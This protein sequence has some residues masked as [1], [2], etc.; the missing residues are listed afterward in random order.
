[1]EAEA[2]L[3]RSL[4]LPIREQLSSLAS[5][6][7]LPQVHRARIEKIFALLTRESLNQAPKPPFPGLSYI[8]ANGLPFQWV[9]RFGG[10][11]S[12]FGFLCEVGKPGDRPQQRLKL[13]LERL[14]LACDVI[15][16]PRSFWLRNIVDRVIPPQEDEPWPPHLK[17]ALWVGVAAG[18]AGIQLKPY[19]NLN[20]GTA[21]E[22]WLRAGWVLKD[23]GRTRSL[24]RL[25]ELSQCASAGGWPVGLAADILPD[26]NAGRIKIYFRSE[27]VSP[28]WLEHWYKAAGFVRGATAVRR[29]LDLFP[30]LGR[31]PYPS[32]AFILCVESH[33]EDEI[34]LKTDLAVSKWIASDAEVVNGSRSLVS[35]LGGNPKLIEEALGA[36]GA[37]PPNS[38]MLSVMRFVSLGIELDGSHHVNL[39]VEPPL[40]YFNGRGKR[41]ASVTNQTTDEV[42]RA[43]LHYLISQREGSRWTDFCLPVG[44]SDAWVTAYVLARLGDL[45]G[46][47]I[48][49]SQQEKIEE[50]LD[51]LLAQRTQAGGWGYNSEVPDDADSTA[52]AILA[53]RCH[54]REVPHQ[55][56]DVLLRCEEPDGTFATYPA[57]TEPGGGW[58]LAVPDVTAV[59]LK[60]LGR[61]ERSGVDAVLSRWLHPEGLPP[62][63]WWVSPFYTCA[64]LLDGCKEVA[65]IPA[66][67][68]LRDWLAQCVPANAFD[69]A[70]LLRCLLGL[71]MEESRFAT[72]RLIRSQQD[73]G[74]WPPSAFLRLTDPAVTD[75]WN[76]IDAGPLYVDHAGVFTTATVLWALVN[77]RKQ[78]GQQLS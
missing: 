50:S 75:P 78:S 25:C 65:M 32:A 22:R 20:R 6:T 43:G 23:L 24:E 39:Y 26:G 47:C 77:K 11:K 48:S 74:S 19:L 51:W 59:A 3:H 10:A 54:G 64:A 52:W 31:K 36:I 44:H 35:A 73:D 30:W 68:A 18:A 37:W 7:D 76:T 15:G 14:E 41:V 71:G 21:R 70:L 56:F 60:A 5:V 67:T 16:S 45:P 58:T 29:C 2:C 27:E 42:I 69:E 55:A 57:G 40:S 33:P 8:N 46:G 62:A 66:M 4:T 61:S 9:F 63:Y 38:G 17:S 13:S 28:T 1:M 34:S 49:S 53:L 12:G 72:E